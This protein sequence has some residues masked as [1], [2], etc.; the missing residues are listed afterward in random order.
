MIPPKMNHPLP[1]LVGTLNL[2]STDLPFIN[3]LRNMVKTAEITSIYR[4]PPTKAF[5]SLPFTYSMMKQSM[6]YAL[7]GKYL[8][9]F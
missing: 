3:C 4:K 5:P 9:N 8:F 1:P 7:L 6:E 2:K